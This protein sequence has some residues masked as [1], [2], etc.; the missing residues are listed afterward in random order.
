MSITTAPTPPG[1]DPSPDGPRRR[2]HRAA[3]VGR[4]ESAGSA[5]PT[6]R[7]AATG[8]PDPDGPSG[9]IRMGRI[10]TADDPGPVPWTDFQN[11]G[12]D[13]FWEVHRASN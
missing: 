8:S 5:Q 6:S 11:A 1:T 7:R 10:Y 2:A 3:S 13:C 9:P 12:P 4:A